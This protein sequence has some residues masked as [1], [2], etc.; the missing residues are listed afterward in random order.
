MKTDTIP[1]TY[2][3]RKTPCHVFTLELASGKTWYAVEGSQNVN[4]SPCPLSLGVDVEEI[5]DI[6]AFTW[7]GGIDSEKTL[8]AAIEA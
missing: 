8:A 3:S 5:E 1:A 4:L 7:P 2:G 6:D